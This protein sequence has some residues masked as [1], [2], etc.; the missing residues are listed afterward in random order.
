MKIL[1]KMLFTLGIV[2]SLMSVGALAHAQIVDGQQVVIPY[3]TTVNGWWTGLAVF[4]SSNEIRT[5]R[6]LCLD[7][8]GEVIGTYL[9]SIRPFET[10]VG[11]LDSFISELRYVQKRVNICFE[12]VGTEPFHITMFMGNDV[13]GFSFFS[14]KSELVAVNDDIF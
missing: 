6:V 9:A 12:T 10:V 7:E 3:A 4:N 14:Y 8:S 5:F 13:G 2:F 11:A 1:R